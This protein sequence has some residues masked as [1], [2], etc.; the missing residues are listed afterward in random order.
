[1]A[2]R[3][4]EETELTPAFL[5]LEW[6]I[7]ETLVSYLCQALAAWTAVEFSPSDWLSGKTML[8]VVLGVAWEQE[9]RGV[10]GRE[11]AI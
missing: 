7:Q 2:G 1:M 5:G 6:A 8:D 10:G 9:R 11:A 3:E 4:T